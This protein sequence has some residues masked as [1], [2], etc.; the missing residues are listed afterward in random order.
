MSGTSIDNGNKNNYLDS[1]SI[2]PKNLCDIRVKADGSFPCSAN[3]F[4]YNR[5]QTIDH[6][7]TVAATS[8]GKNKEQLYF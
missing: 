2:A 8:G 4:T 1:F 3:V 5:D 7:N 6:L